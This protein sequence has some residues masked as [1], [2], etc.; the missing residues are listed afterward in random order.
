MFA[1]IG[2]IIA[3][4]VVLATGGLAEAQRA[5]PPAPPPPAIAVAPQPWIGIGINDRGSIGV[6]VTTVWEPA[7]SAGVLEGDEVL[8]VGGVRVASADELIRVV[9]NEKA[10]STVTL[11][12]L[13]AGKL[14]TL[15]VTLD[16][17]PSNSELVQRLLLDKP[18]PVLE[19]VRASGGAMARLLDH[20]GDVVV[21]ALFHPSCASCDPVFAQL[22]TLVRD[23]SP[24][25]V[26]GALLG[27]RPSAESF[28]S[29]RGL[30]FDVL[31]IDEEM[32]TRWGLF[33]VTAP[34]IAVVDP[35]GVVRYAGAIDG[36]QTP[37]AALRAVA[38]ETDQAIFAAGRLARAKR[39]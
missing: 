16:V 36:G 27:S 3:V 18:A 7:L 15:P 35:R 22:A 9:R 24:V 32:R 33:D 30:S 34:V 28:A 25:S 4:S 10:G 26:V 13:R 6:A 39:R 8:S 38:V 5:Q 12:I 17:K 1:R 29:Y 21:V 37:E 19:G 23:K 20:R 2:V 14:R 11:E 31:A